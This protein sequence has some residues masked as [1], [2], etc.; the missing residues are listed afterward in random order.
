LVIGVEKMTDFSNEEVARALAMAADNTTEFNNGVTFPALHALVA[1]AYLNKYN[2]APAVLD[3]VSVRSH[4]KAFADDKAQF[5]KKITEDDVRASAM[6]TSPLK[7]YHCSPISDGAAA[8]V[9]STEQTDLEL[10]ASVTLASREFALADRSD[11]TSF[12]VVQEAVAKLDLS[13]LEIVEVH[14]C[15]VIAEIIALED[16]GIMRKG[17]GWQE[18]EHV[19]VNV[20][21][22]LKAGGHAIGATGVK[23]MV[24]LAEEMR[25]H[26]YQLGLAHNVGGVG[27]QV[28]LNLIKKR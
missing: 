24:T 6:V 10:A 17:Q 7:L 5:H 1:Q 28:A 2:L 4:Q 15:F 3:A 23:Q 27:A 25:T 13:E 20:R 11:L 12:A 14:D 21:G 22:G 16:L 19:K 18:P 8:I 9:L 26:Q